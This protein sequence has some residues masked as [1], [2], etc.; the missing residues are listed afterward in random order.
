MIAV[1]RTME[2]TGLNVNL[3]KLENLIEETAKG[4]NEIEMNL[5]HSLGTK[6]DINFN[7]S[8]DVSTI[9][10][11]I[12]GVNPVTTRSG[13]CSTARRI[14]KGI[15]NPLTDEIIKY[16]DL[17]RLLSSLNAI[18]NAT[19]KAKG[20]IYCTYDDACPSGRLYTKSYSF[21]SIP[22]TARSVIYADNGCS[23]I[24]A[25]YDSFEL[26]ILSALAHDTY[27]KDCWAKGRD[28]HRKVVSD[29]KGIPYDSVTKKQRQLGKAL[30][31]GLA[32]GMAAG[33]LVRK[34]DIPTD[35]AQALMDNY[36][37]K[38]PAIESFK[39]EAIKKARATGFTE[40]YH[41]RKRF[42]PDIT[43]PYIRDR[44]KAERRVINTM[45]QGTA[46]DIVKFALIELHA[47]GFIIN[48]MVHDSILLTVPEDRVESS[49]KQIKEIMEIEING[50]TFK[51]TCRTGH[52]W[53]DCCK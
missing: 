14:L 6:E 22:E 37:S 40:T 53:L 20:K 51:V 11:E 38:I 18:H 8:K 25:D 52:A 46:A 9:L 48:T 21:Q 43:S 50:M 30:N 29:M 34:L 24:L 35:E 28:L 31:F 7:S 47:Q 26:R 27:F 45:I 42:L 16:R 44:K 15:H 5:K 36:K 1:K 4:K 32:Y 13:R 3:S 10:T 23:F 2:K 41:G 17:E 33:G 19:D 39:I 49:L 12:L